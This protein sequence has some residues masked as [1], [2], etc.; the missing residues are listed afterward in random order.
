MDL[1][2]NY[3]KQKHKFLSEEGGHS[4]NN[5]QHKLSLNPNPETF[6]FDVQ[7][8]IK[9]QFYTPI[10]YLYLEVVYHALTR[11]NI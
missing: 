1:P 3:P 9:S 4:F 10:N 6:F 7:L 2:S 11:I 5:H 8:Q